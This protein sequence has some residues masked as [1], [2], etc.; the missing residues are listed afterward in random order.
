MHKAVS[1]AALGALKAILEVTRKQADQQYL[2]D[3]GC[4][5]VGPVA[6][7][8]TA[9]YQARMEPSMRPFSTCPEAGRRVQHLVGRHCHRHVVPEDRPRPAPYAELL[10]LVIPLTL[11]EIA[12]AS[13]VRIVA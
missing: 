8:H 13:L 11:C 6:D 1:F 7:I 12:G 4:D 5:C 9:E 3:L 10:G 2:D